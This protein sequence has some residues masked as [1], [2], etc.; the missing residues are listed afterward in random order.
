MVSCE[1]PNQACSTQDC[2]HRTRALDGLA[3]QALV[4][5]SSADTSGPRPD[6]VLTP[7]ALTHTC[8]LL[9]SAQLPAKNEQEQRCPGKAKDLS[10]VI[11]PTYSEKIRPRE[12]TGQ[13]Q[14]DLVYQ[15]W[16]DLLLAL[17]GTVP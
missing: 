2:D 6:N 10:M 3:R 12:M 15:S 1:N 13:G 16:S 17:Q 11:Q 7:A 9:R 8:V 14:D 4:L 5:P